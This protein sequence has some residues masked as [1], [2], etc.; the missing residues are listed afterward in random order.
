MALV[1]DLLPMHEWSIVS[2]IKLVDEPSVYNL[3][4]ALGCFEVGHWTLPFPP[5]LLGDAVVAE[6]VPRGFENRWVF[7]L[8]AT[9]GALLHFLLL[10]GCWYCH[11]LCLAFLLVGGGEE[12]GYHFVGGEQQEETWR[13][14]EDHDGIGAGL[15][16]LLEVAELRFGGPVLEVVELVVGHHQVQELEHH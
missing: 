2:K 11:R 5:K 7:K 6:N 1:I 16:L 15:L 10:D 9:D 8:V 14:E 3:H 13:F 12:L 4:I